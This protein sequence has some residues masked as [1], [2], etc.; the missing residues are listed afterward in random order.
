VGASTP[1]TGAF[2]TLTESGVISG[3]A[4]AA[5]L[6]SPPPIGGTTGNTGTFTTLSGSATVGGAG[7]TALFA[8]PPAIGGTAPSTGAFTTLSVTGGGTLA[9]TFTGLPTYVG[10]PIFSGGALASLAINSAAW[11]AHFGWIQVDANSGGVAWVAR[12]A[13]AAGVNPF[14]AG[15]NVSG[16]AT[17]A[18]PAQYLFT[19]P[20][21]T[22]DSSAANDGFF[23]FE[24]VQNVQNGAKG[25]HT[26]ALLQ[27]TQN[28]TLTTTRPTQGIGA[29]NAW[30]FANGTGAGRGVNAIVFNPQLSVGASASGYT[31][32]ELIE[33]NVGIPTG[34]TGIYIRAG[35]T[36]FSA[37]HVQGSASD[38]AFGALL[39]GTI[40]WRN[41]FQVGRKQSGNWG[42]DTTAGSILAAEQQTNG[43]AF[44]PMKAK[45]GVQFSGVLFGGYAW[46]SAGAL[47]DPV[48]NWTLGTGK[49]GPT[50]TGVAID[51]AG[52]VGGSPTISNGGVGYTSG[53]ILTDPVYGAIYTVTGVSGFGTITSGT[54]TQAPYNFGGAG[55]STIAFAG[56]TSGGVDGQAAVIGVRWTQ[57]TVLSLQPSRGSLKVGSA[58]MTANGSVATA[59]TSIGP[60]GSHTTVQEWLTVTN[61][62]GVVRYIP[63]F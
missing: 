62:S 36:M 32:A 53:D 9:G 30:V 11:L 60:T 18:D 27:V 46:Q 12:T 58:L 5:Y 56:G 13:N 22:L 7:I 29:L 20:S 28:G 41:A 3:A 38:Y 15:A 34:V 4:F 8:S 42:V 63:A 57:Q 48:G 49:I 47:L 54:L 40:G 19:I 2:T 37:G 23:G 21:D 52:Y 45:N 44:T 59:L 55:T 39:S 43:G 33:G 31:L 51:V 16:T 24:F 61:S 6:A 1:S 50:S 17:T 14:F 10:T 25:T 26:G 35:D